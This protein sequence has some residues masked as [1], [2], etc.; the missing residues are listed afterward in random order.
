MT[1]TVDMPYPA[2]TAKYDAIASFLKKSS[3]LAGENKSSKKLIP[4]RGLRKDIPEQIVFK[5]Q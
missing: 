2:S 1:A 4:V 5:Y 3:V